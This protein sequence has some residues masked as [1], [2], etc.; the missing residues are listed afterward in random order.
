[1]QDGTARQDKTVPSMWL[2]D[3]RSASEWGVDWQGLGV[4]M[5]EPTL[6]GQDWE[7]AGAWMVAGCRSWWTMDGLRGRACWRGDERRGG[8]QWRGC[9]GEYVWRWELG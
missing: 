4:C 3:S 8:R 2:I 5:R 1:M 9:E 6:A 7:G